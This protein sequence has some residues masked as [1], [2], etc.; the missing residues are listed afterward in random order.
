[1]AHAT[2]TCH[3]SWCARMSS[4]CATLARPLSLS[5]RSV[6]G[7]RAALGM[8]PL[9]IGATRDEL[10]WIAMSTALSAPKATPHHMHIIVPAGDNQTI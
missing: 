4:S 8:A 9:E 10:R 3:I 1:M 5:Q 6:E 2:L 7:S